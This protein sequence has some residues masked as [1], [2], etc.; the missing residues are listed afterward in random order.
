MLQ[1][2]GGF[3]DER[4]VISVGSSQKHDC[5]HMKR[6]FKVYTD[7]KQLHNLINLSFSH[8]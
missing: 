1:N 4:Q 5:H 6:N 7:R 8:I 3:N 2:M